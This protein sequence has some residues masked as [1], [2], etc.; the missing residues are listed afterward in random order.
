MNAFNRGA[1]FWLIGINLLLVAALAALW[2]APG[3]PARWRH[4]QPPAAQAPSLDDIQ[5]AILVANP[6][7]TAAYPAVLE[8]PLTSPTRRPQAAAPTQAASAPPPTAIEQIRLLGIVAGPALNG[9]MIEQ[10][11]KTSFVRRGERVGDWSLD[12]LQGRTATFVRNGERRNLDLP[13]AHGAAAAPAD[14]S[15]PR[16]PGVAAG[17]AAGAPPRA[18]PTSPPAAPAPAPAPSARP[19]AP[20][21][22]AAPA[23]PSASPDRPKAAFG[24]AVPEKPA[25]PSR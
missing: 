17:A 14:A 6:A 11:G 13:I 24:G 5:A 10:G 20:T 2:L 8:R 12:A 9:V 15:A 25:D 21:A 1:T 23:A 16:A 7:A 22:P 19:P 4:W 3:A 18:R